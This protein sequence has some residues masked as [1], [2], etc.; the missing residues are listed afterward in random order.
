MPRL[1]PT[2]ARGLARLLPPPVPGAT[3]LWDL[4]SRVWL[5][6]ALVLAVATFRDY[7][8]TMD[9]APHLS[10]GVHILHWYSSGFT[11]DTALTFRANY[12]YGGGYDLL[13]AIFRGL[14]LPLSEVD[15]L[16]LL[17]C[18]VGVFGLLGTWKLG[19]LLA[20][21]R[22]GFLALV[23]V[24]L[25][26]VLYGHMFNNPKDTPF[27]V[28]YVW[29]LY[30]MTAVIAALPRPPRRALLGL[31][32]AVGLATSVRIGGLLLLCYLAL[33][34]GLYTLASGWLRRS[35]DAGEAHG[36]HA[37]RIGLGVGVGA[38]A[39]MLLGWPWAQLDPLRRPFIALLRMSSYD[40][41]QRK[42]PFAGVEVPNADI[43]PEYLVHYFGLQTPELTLALVLG[44]TLWGVHLLLRRGLDPTQL[45]RALALLLLGLAIWVPPL[46]AVVKGSLLYDAYRH[47]LFI[48][49]AFCVLAALSLDQLLAGLQ[50]AWGR[51]AALAGGLLF[52]LASGDIAWTM[53]RMHPHQYVY[54]NRLIGGL[55]GAVGN[56]D[57]DYYGQ[58]YKEAVEGM[59][60]HLWQTER[61]QYMNTIYTFSACMSNWAVARHAPPNLRGH[62][63]KTGPGPDFH[64][65]Y[66]RYHCDQRHPGAPVVFRVEREGG[67]LAVVKDLRP[68]KAAAA[69][70]R[71]EDPRP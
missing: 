49:P 60:R 12:Y 46:Y 50:R 51:A 28:A 39:V 48:V 71:S 52:A 69:A 15:A 8:V 13:G 11:D 34:L 10:Y 27:A 5:V 16:H 24:T 36:F 47:F 25:N 45:R 54:F 56:Y 58:S 43:G 61:R 31:A 37:L 17:G 18:L 35:A 22:A 38:W 23:L 70:K 30:F 42:M 1:E 6:V 66:H 55:G 4:A 9:E 63:Q 44:G 67:E 14:V 40:A 59:H 19:R 64:A 7:G 68:L 20:G 62:R 29:S 57:T 41:H 65:G 32:V 2:P 26:P 21:P 3:N 53:L 33:V